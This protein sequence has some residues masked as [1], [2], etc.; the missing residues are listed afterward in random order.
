[1]KVE[2]FGKIMNGEQKLKGEHSLYKYAFSLVNHD[3]N[4][5]SIFTKE[6]GTVLRLVGRF[7]SESEIIDTVN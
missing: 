5:N 4:S 6:L 7:P 2:G 1:M 3:E